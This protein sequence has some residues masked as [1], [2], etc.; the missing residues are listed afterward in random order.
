MPVGGKGLERSARK[1][2]TGSPNLK[3]S[4]LTDAQKPWASKASLDTKA[5]EAK[6]LLPA[7]VPALENICEGTR[8]EEAQKMISAAKSLEKLVA[9]GD[10]AS[11]FL[12]SSELEKAIDNY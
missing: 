3:P 8:K 10:A 5:G 6:H 4:M 9:L 12:T 2:T 11:T 7:L 1:G